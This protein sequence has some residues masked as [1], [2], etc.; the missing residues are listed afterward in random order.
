MTRYMVAVVLLLSL[1]RAQ[2]QQNIF[3]P[4][5]MEQTDHLKAYCILDWV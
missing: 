5:D 3:I 2:A 1:G 4:M